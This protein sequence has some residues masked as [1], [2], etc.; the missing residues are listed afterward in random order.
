MSNQS[1]TPHEFNWNIWKADWKTWWGNKLDNETLKKQGQEEK[2]KEM[3]ELKKSGGIP[4]RKSGSFDSNVSEVGM[5]GAKMG[6][7]HKST[8]SFFPE[9]KYPAFERN[10]YDDELL[11]QQKLKNEIGSGSA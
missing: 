1:Q 10:K 5:R 8:T 3:N 9:W 6:E 2:C 11:R 7:G 4:L